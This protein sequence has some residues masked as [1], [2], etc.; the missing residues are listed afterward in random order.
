[1][2]KANQVQILLR[3]FP[4]ARKLAAMFQHLVCLHNLPPAQATTHNFRCLPQLLWGSIQLQCTCVKTNNEFSSTAKQHLCGGP[5]TTGICNAERGQ[6]LKFPMLSLITDL[7]PPMFPLH[8][9]TLVGQPNSRF[10]NT[11]PSQETCTQTSKDWTRGR[12]N[13]I[14]KLP[15]TNWKD[16]K[17]LP[18]VLH[19]M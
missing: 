13:N 15:R 10:C 1:M 4:S 16:A 9:L 18:K 2:L 5:K 6:P 14:K 3:P 7:M 17:L 12:K 8:L 11:D 19:N